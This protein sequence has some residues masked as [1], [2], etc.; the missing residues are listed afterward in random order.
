MAFAKIRARVESMILQSRVIVTVPTNSG[1]YALN[2]P[3]LG[4]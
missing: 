2:D 4:K 3:K 1:S